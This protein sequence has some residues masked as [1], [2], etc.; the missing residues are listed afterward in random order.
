MLVALTLTDPSNVKKAPTGPN[1]QNR[2]SQAARNTTGLRGDSG[3]GAANRGVSSTG[4]TPHA[5]GTG[6]QQP[7]PSYTFDYSTDP[8]LQQINAQQT[9][10]IAQSQ[11]DALAQQKAALIAYGDPNLAMSVLGDKLT[12]DAAANNPDSA[13]AQLAA[14]NQ[15][16]TRDLTESENKSNLLYSS[17]YGYKSGLLQ[18]AY[19]GSQANAAA[20]VQGKLGTIGSQLLAAEQAAYDKEIQGQQDAYTRALQNPVGIPTPTATALQS[21]VARANAQGVFPASPL[22]PTA[23]AATPNKTGASAN[24][25][26]GVFAVH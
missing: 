23:A 21:G 8:I 10:V 19:L 13:L 24:P 6:A 22:G 25:Q 26:Q 17:D 15:S 9:M 1:P 20:D 11:A 12:A 3:A 2:S 18:K 5:A 7:A 16:D 14:K 4:A